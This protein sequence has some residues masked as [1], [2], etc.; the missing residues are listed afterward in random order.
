MR[1]YNKLRFSLL[2][3]VVQLVHTYTEI[4]VDLK[5]H[6]PFIPGVRHHLEPA[7]QLITK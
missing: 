2:R 7:E 6:V 1:V 3:N 5:V 4:D